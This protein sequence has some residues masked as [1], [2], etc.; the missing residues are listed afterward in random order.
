MD[1]RIATFNMENLFTRPAAMAD[2]AGPD[3]T[4]ASPTMPSSTTLSKNRLMMR[5]TRRG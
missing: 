4:A 2:D 1:L 5:P 3:G